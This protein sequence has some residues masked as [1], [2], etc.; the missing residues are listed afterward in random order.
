MW[1]K[2]TGH[3]WQYSA[4]TLHAGYLRL[5]THTQNIQYLL[6][7]HSYN[8]YTNPPQYY[9]Y[10]YIDS[11][12]SHLNCV[13]RPN[14]DPSMLNCKTDKCA[15]TCLSC[16]LWFMQKKRKETSMEQEFMKYWK[17]VCKVHLYLKWVTP[18]QCCNVGSSNE[19]KI[20][21]NL[22]YFCEYHI[23]HWSFKIILPWAWKTILVVSSLLLVQIMTT[24]NCAYCMLFCSKDTALLWL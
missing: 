22:K 3:K 5:Q 7:F 20:I 11:L 6:L 19:N 14:S 1:Q 15:W 12:V 4:C 23:K 24:F 18:W 2:K 17:V 21:Y 13:Q 8:G 9:V 16:S 10:M